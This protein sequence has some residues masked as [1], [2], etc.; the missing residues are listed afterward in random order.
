MYENMGYRY[1]IGLG[2]H[3]VHDGDSKKKSQ[4]IEGKKRNGM[5]KLVSGGLDCSLSP[6]F[7]QSSCNCLFR[8]TLT[9]P[10]LGGTSK[11]NINETSLRFHLGGWT[12]FAR[13][14]KI[15][16]NAILFS[17]RALFF[18]CGGGLTAKP[19]RAIEASMVRSL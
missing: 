14:R 11:N 1:E 18:G 19:I 8:R 13:A 4:I 17:V 6:Y 7:F 10:G 2:I 15:I 3:L 9:S 5:R 16:V 12:H